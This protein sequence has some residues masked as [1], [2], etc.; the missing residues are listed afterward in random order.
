MTKTSGIWLPWVGR[1]A[2]L[3][4]AVVIP[5]CGSGGTGGQGGGLLWQSQSGTGTT[6]NG[7]PVGWIDP[8]SGLGGGPIGIIQ[9][10]ASVDDATYARYNVST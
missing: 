6:S 5:A 1:L 9:I 3:L 10:I 2:A 4:V 7:Q 8:N